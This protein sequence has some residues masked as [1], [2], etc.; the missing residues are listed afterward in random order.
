MGG[1]GNM[2]QDV[3]WNKP[4]GNSTASNLVGGQGGIDSMFN[5]VSWDKPFGTDS[6]LGQALYGNQNAPLNADGTPKDPN[7][8]TAPNPN[9]PPGAGAGLPMVVPKSSP[10]SSAPSGPANTLG[11]RQGTLPSYR[12]NANEDAFRQSMLSSLKPN[13]G[14]T[15]QGQNSPYKAVTPPSKG[16]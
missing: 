3:S 2:F 6:T 14:F 12:N 8:T 13:Y 7:Y 5:T 15:F 9:A 4:F 11:M 16:V 10:S 1:G